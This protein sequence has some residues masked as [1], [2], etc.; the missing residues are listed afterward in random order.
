MFTIGELSKR[1]GVHIET[2]RYYERSGILPKA[3][4][5][6][7]GRRTYGTADVQRLVF[8]RHARELGFELSAVRTL[9]NLQEHPDATCEKATQIA[10]AQLVAIES[11]I[12]RLKVLRSELT[13]MIEGCGNVRVAECGIIEA[14]SAA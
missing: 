1:T 9:L 5:T 7:N 4:R 3:M 13:Q 14:L 8:I 11:K 12:S 10:A 6:A 2:V